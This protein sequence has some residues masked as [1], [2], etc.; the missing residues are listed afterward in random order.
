VNW[1]EKLRK[2]DY[3]GRR[4]LYAALAL[5]F[6]V[7]L[8]HIAAPIA[9][10][11]SWNQVSA[12]TVIRHFVEDGIDP[13]HPQWDVLT[14]P[15]VGPRIEAEEAPIY[16]VA[17]ALLAK[18]YG[19]HEPLARLLS[20]IASLLGAVFLYRLTRRLADG[21]AAFF[22]AVFYLF[23]PFSWYFGRAIMSDAWM[24]AMI[25]LAVERFEFWTR[26]KCFAALLTAAG[27]VALA[28]L[29]KPFALHVGVALLLLQ[30]AR[31]GFKSLFDVK[32]VVFALIALAPPLAWVAYAAS[33]GSLGNVVGSGES[34]LTAQHIWGPPSLLWS[35]KFWFTIQARL[36]DQM[37]TPLVTACA[38][39]AFVW[40]D[41]RKQTG[42]ALAWLA[43]FLVYLLLV[44][45][46]NQMHN[47][48][49]LPALP[50]LAL[51]G[52]IGLSALS[53]RIQ[54]KWIALALPVFLLISALYVRTSFELDLSSQKA[55]E[56][57]RAVSRRNELIVVLDPGATR[58]N[59]AIY[60]AHRRGWHERALHETTLAQRRAWGARWLVS[61]LED[62]QIA[63][64]PQWLQHM[65][66]Y[67]RLFE[68]RGPWGRNGQEHTIAIYDLS[69]PAGALVR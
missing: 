34:M 48:Y 33:I 3:Y 7:R 14:G 57:A 45:D 54:G 50:A 1:I 68:F 41:G 9:D 27:A 8:W 28:G 69:I 60:A 25:I 5:A 23:A 16:H 2:R 66:R 63:A 61:C 19:P 62:E 22:A 29:F 21:P 67:H 40:A 44:R 58:K 15:A 31:G 65:N 13:L 36:F 4:L 52:G 56:W 46:G 32:L 12:A 6:L 43:G 38:V 37:A 39:A 24:L 18:L 10:R 42:V 49:Q 11:H 20:I 53:R 51:L 35:P 17:V 26:E 55:G 47:Y 64:H 30:L 59:Q